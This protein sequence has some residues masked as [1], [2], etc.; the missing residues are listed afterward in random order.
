M[1]FAAHAADAITISAYFDQTGPG[2]PYAKRGENG[3]NLAI[4]EAKASGALKVDIKSI[5]GDTGGNPQR[6]ATLAG[7]AVSSDAS[8][9]IYGT[10]SGPALAMAPAMQQAKLPFIVVQA[11]TPKLLSVGDYIYT[12]SAYYRT[13][14]ELYAKF[15][16]SKGIKKLAVVYTGDAP[17]FNE[18]GSKDYVEFGRKYGFE[19]ELNEVAIS[20]TDFTTV[21]RKI[22]ASQPD[23]IAFLLY[24]PQSA[25]F[26]SLLRQAEYKGYVGAN[27]VTDFLAAAGA[28]ANGIYS[29]APFSPAISCEGGRKFAEAY[30]KAYGAAADDIAANGYNAG[31]MLVR[32]IEIANGN[33]TRENMKAS[34]DKVLAEGLKDTSTCTLSFEGH[35]VKLPGILVQIED[36]KQIEVKLQ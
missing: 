27:T 26:I 6:A 24:G 17:S 10:S 21:T 4:E 28:Q 14:H 12:S 11:V 30:Q 7:E 31:R 23:A 1:A 33:Y 15:L 13:F 5:K 25:T 18:L 35:E 36:G 16:G 3:F 29:P 2:G 20:T 22:V 19:V 34:M 9:V 8:V 32:A